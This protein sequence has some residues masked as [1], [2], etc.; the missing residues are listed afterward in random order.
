[1]NKGELIT[2]IAENA[3]LSIAQA[4]EVMDTLLYTIG[5]SLR[6]GNKVSLFGFGT[7]TAK[8]RKSRTGR[9]PKTGEQI[10]IP[11]KNVVKFKPGKELEEI[12]N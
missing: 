8:E 12:L 3:D 7:F 10:I 4:T 11:S 1:M 6:D 2:R 9:N 5:D